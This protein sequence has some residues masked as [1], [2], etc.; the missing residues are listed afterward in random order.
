MN[1]NTKAL[2]RTWETVTTYTACGENWG[3]VTRTVTLSREV[4]GGPISATVNGEAVNVA[5]A[6][7]LL[8]NADTMTLTAEV[9][10]TEPATIGKARAAR[11]HRLMGRIGLC[12]PDHYGNARRALGRDVFS[13]ASLTEQ[14]A[15]RFWIHLWRTFPAIRHAV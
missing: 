7:R 11:L 1:T 14:E 15:R 6:D 2:S 3:S 12:G 9:L 4:L 13:L 5:R 10:A 8:R